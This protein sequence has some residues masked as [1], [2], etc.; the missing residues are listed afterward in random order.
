MTLIALLAVVAS[1]VALLL[2]SLP[3]ALVYDVTPSELAGRPLDQPV[4]LYG[5]VVDGSVQFAPATGILVFKV[6]DG[7]A[8]VSVTTRSIPSELFRDGVGVVLAGRMTQPGQFAAD[9]LIVKHSAVYAPLA[10][11]A[12]IPPGILEQAGDSP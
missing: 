10:P 2:I 9:Q 3:G 4:R 11:G 6:T 12:T 8:T 7:Q 5:I 1:F